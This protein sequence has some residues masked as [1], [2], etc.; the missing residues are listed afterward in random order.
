VCVALR[1]ISYDRS[2]GINLLILKGATSV[3]LHH[4]NS[5]A[6]ALMDL[7]PNIKF[8]KSRFSYGIFLLLLLSFVL[9]SLLTSHILRSSSTFN[10]FI[11]KM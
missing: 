9:S 2:F 4:K 10:K 6:Q 3:M 7:F 5:V 1:S 8:E 11:F